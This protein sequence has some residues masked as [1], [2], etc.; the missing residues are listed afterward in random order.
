M[1]LTLEE[2]KCLESFS[3]LYSGGLDSCAVALMMG[4][5]IPGGVHL[6]YIHA[7]LRYVLQ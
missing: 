5:L 7:Q 6:T 2:Y 1:P 4:K 3:V